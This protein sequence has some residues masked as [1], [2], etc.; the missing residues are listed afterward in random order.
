MGNFAK[1]YQK[2]SEK[3]NG[4]F[5]M[6]HELRKDLSLSRED[7]NQLIESKMVTGHLAG[8]CGDPSRLSS[9]QL[10]DSFWGSDGELYI[11][12]VLRG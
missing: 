8:R 11:A 10:K 9:G 4:R 5:A 3:H 1:A 2:L 7:F 12:V 6:V